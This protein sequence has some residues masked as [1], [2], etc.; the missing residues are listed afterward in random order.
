MTVLAV[1][2]VV[3]GEVDEAA[4]A[5]MLRSQLS[6]AEDCR[7]SNRA[8]MDVLADVSRSVSAGGFAA[9][10]EQ[11]AASTAA[12]NEHTERSTAA[13]R[14]AAD[15]I[16]AF[17]TAVAAFEA[18][19]RDLQEL[20]EG[21]KR[22][23]G[24]ITSIASQSS[25][26]SLNARIEASRAGEAGK[27]FEV[28]AREIGALSKETSALSDDVTGDMVRLEATLTT[29]LQQFAASR[30]E[31]AHASAAVGALEA[32][33]SG[34]R[35]EATSLCGVSERVETIAYAQVGAQ[36]GLE[37]VTRHAEWVRDASVT[38]VDAIGT[39][40]VRIERRNRGK[41]AT[42]AAAT[43]RDFEQFKNLLAGALKSG[44]PELG[45]KAALR[46][47][48]I[49]L[50]PMLVLE[51]LSGAVAHSA[52]GRVGKEQPLEV[53]YRDGF[54]LRAVLDVLEPKLAGAAPRGAPTIVL[55]NAYEDHHDL[56][57]RLV[58]L[59]LRAAGCRVVDLGLSVRN[60]TFVETALRENAD[61]VG[62]SALLLH[63]ARWIPELKREFAR[64]GRADLPVIAG[65]AIFL[66]DPHLR[67]RFEADGVGRTPDD[68]VRLVRGIVAA[69]RLAA[70]A[71]EVRR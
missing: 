60:E 51:A 18:G 40:C 22:T 39:A 9:A 65:G 4:I 43:I 64:R 67:E 46:A 68:A 57:R 59:H 21:V 29:T 3:D 20:I 49:G 5:R 41:D 15:A 6:L 55:G 30:D 71:S 35:A 1:S 37:A 45:A 58:A 12:L 11:L 54:V 69:R 19:F 56:G 50:E 38:L 33:A 10:T 32:A 36:N 13:C 63:T 70:G 14:D 53:Y 2:H 48:E 8:L 7:S 24:K 27:G 31:L 61:V 34:I 66:V 52:L 26:L 17:T 25:I 62:V 28:V 47:F 44:D 16:R 42:T 23:T